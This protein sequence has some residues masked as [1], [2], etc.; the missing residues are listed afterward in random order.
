MGFKFRKSIKIAPGIK[1]NFNKKSTGVTFGGKGVKYTHNSKGKQT[2]SLGI[3]GTGLY[4]T[5][6]TGGNTKKK[7][8]K[9]T[10]TT[11]GIYI[12]TENKENK[13]ILFILIMMHY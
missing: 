10:K 13:N 3:P 9:S 12:N 4:Y 1:L 6:T 11:N 8:G 2:K 5:T 7:S